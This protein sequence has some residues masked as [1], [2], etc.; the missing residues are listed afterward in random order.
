MISVGVSSLKDQLSLYLQYVKTGESVI[1]TEH[2][3]II[4]ELSI[5]KKR[6][7]ISAFEQ[8][9]VQLHKAGKVILAKKNTSL[10]KKPVINEK[11]D[12]EAIL[13]EVRADRI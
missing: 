11:L 13:N 10:V 7:N 4:A 9:L 8:K 12:Y 6:D 2:N 1:I 3:K 5:P